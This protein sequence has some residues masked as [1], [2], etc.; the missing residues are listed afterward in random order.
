[1]GKE[2][3]LFKNEEK[4]DAKGAA[5]FL[6]QLADRIEE[7]EVTLKRGKEKVKLKVPSKVGMMEFFGKVKK[8]KRINEGDLSSAY[9]TGQGKKLPVLFI[10]NGKSTKKALAM[11]DKDFKNNF[12]MLEF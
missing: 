5:S 12:T 7:G 1:M 3:V 10:T 11:I 9:I 8:K 4:I 2:T 6:R